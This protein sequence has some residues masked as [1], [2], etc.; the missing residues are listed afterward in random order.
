MKSQKMWVFVNNNFKN[1]WMGLGK[2][3]EKYC[4][5]RNKGENDKCVCV[6]LGKKLKQR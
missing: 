5:Q 3:N 4:G 1:E 6:C 2:L